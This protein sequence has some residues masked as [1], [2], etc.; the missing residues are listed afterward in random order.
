MDN[1]TLEDITAR[2][3]EGHG[4]SI[5]EALALA[6][7]YSTDELCDAADRVRARWCGNSVDTCSIVNARSGRCGEDC[8]WCA[9]SRHHH[10][11]IAEYDIIPDIEAL[12]AAE[13]ND[14]AGVHRFSLV[15]SGRKVNRC[16][17]DRFFRIYKDIRENTGLFLCASMGL[18][19]R[20]ELQALYDA[21]VRRYHCNLETG[22][23]YFPKL[24]STHTHADKLRTIADARAV[25]MEICSGGIIGMGEDMR[26]RLELAYEAYSA[27][28]CSIPVNILQPIKGTAL[29]DTPLISEDEIIRSVALFRFIAPKA[30]LRFAGGRARLSAETT[31][32]ILR[33]GMNGALVG[34]MLT[35]I[36]NGMDDD[37]RLFDSV[38][39]PAK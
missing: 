5:D 9:Q 32:R 13:H 14:R 31:R 1:I 2:A 15:T 7:K 17:M 10:T 20:E 35:T 8:K 19:G 21:G 18:L 11:G 33:G 38:G 6:D 36:G 34:D 4:A 37:F 25:G 26:Q 23:S 24:C 16:D 3:L 27:G 28:A 12:K 39:M 22:S 30:T 29:E